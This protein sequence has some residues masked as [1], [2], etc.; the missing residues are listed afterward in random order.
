MDVAERQDRLDQRTL[1]CRERRRRHAGFH[2][3]LHGMRVLIKRGQETCGVFQRLVGHE[4]EEACGI[5]V[6]DA[7]DPVNEQATA[8]GVLAL[9]ATLHGFGNGAGNVCSSPLE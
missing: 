5:W 1:E 6:V 7:G 4:S 9:V 8:G 2:D 3:E